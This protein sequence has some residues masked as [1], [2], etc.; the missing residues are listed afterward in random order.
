MWIPVHSHACVSTETT[1]CS[2]RGLRVILGIAHNHQLRWGWLRLI[3]GKWIHHDSK[4]QYFMAKITTEHSERHKSLL[5]NSLRVGLFF[6]WWEESSFHALQRPVSGHN[7]T[8]RHLDGGHAFIEPLEALKGPAWPWSRS[9]RLSFTSVDSMGLNVEMRTS[10]V[11]NHR[12]QDLSVSVGYGQLC[13]CTSSSH[14]SERN[15]TLIFMSDL[16]QYVCLYD[17]VHLNAARIVKSNRRCA[18]A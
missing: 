15:V 17:C 1:P 12:R 8:V 16:T 10:P 3:E 5:S 9:N 7:F 14:V 18:L 4:L 2:L 11:V 6:F 13:D